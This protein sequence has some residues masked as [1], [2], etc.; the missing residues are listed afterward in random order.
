MKRL[1]WDAKVRMQQVKLRTKGLSLNREETVRYMVDRNVDKALRKVEKGFQQ[2]EKE[3]GFQMTDREKRIQHEADK[4]RLAYLAS[5]KDTGAPEGGEGEGAAATSANLSAELSGEG[6]RNKLVAAEVARQRERRRALVNCNFDERP[7]LFDVGETSK[8]RRLRVL[9]S[10][11]NPTQSA[12]M[13]HLTAMHRDMTEKRVK[14]VLQEF[15]S[16]RLLLQYVAR[17]KNE[18]ALGTFSRVDEHFFFFFSC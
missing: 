4:L 17:F 16:K 10:S 2:M 8:E 9:L 18:G 14:E 5:L 12:L 15:P 7:E 1:K 6:A 13:K 3:S 11:S